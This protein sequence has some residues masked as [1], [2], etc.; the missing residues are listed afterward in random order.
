M[1]KSD[2]VSRIPAWSAACRA[3]QRTGLVSCSAVTISFVLLIETELCMG[4]NQQHRLF[5]HPHVLMLTFHADDRCVLLLS[6]GE[7]GLGKSTLINSLFLTDLY[8][9]RVIPGAA[10]KNAKK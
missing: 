6:K 3:S 1:L 10:G 5:I 4:C 9:E 2:L 7:S 8:P